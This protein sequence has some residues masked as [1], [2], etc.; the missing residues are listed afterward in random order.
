M[1]SGECEQ[2]EKPDETFAF[3]DLRQPDT[4]QKHPKC[5][6]ARGRKLP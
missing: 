1:D 4:Q 5:K 3:A 6:T 2:R